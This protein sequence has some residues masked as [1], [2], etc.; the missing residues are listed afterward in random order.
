MDDLKQKSD[1]ELQD[2]M[3]AS[4]DNQ[5]VPS[6]IY[7]KAKQELEFRTST[8][9]RFDNIHSSN[10]SIGSSN[11]DQITN[12]PISAGHMQKNISRITRRSIL[13][14]LYTY[15]SDGFYGRL[16]E[17]QFWERIFELDNLPS[18]DARFDTMR[19]DIHQHRINNDD[20]D[21][22]WYIEKFDL[23]DI[24]DSVFLKF[25]A[26]F[27]HPEVREPDW[28]TKRVLDKINKNLSYDGIHL[29]EKKYVSGRPILGAKKTDPKQS[30]SQFTFATATGDSITI[31]IRKEVYD[32]IS[33]YLNNED[34]FHAV[35]EAYKVVKEKLREISGKEKASDIFNMNAENNK[36][37]ENIFGETAEVGTP[38]SD[39]FRGVG[40]LNLAI[41]F[42]RNEK[43][44]SLAT[45]IDKNLAIHYISLASLSYDLISRSDKK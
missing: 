36:H 4:I 43:S 20:W 17:V 19:G 26:E 18:S 15:F 31:E 8:P 25:I 27:F 24:E 30:E 37:H 29:Y 5:Y 34:Y 3:R 12:N 7:H 2:I 38:K 1:Q 28:N 10:I 41:Q 33:N 42:L 6:S 45:Q 9:Q 40:Y 11:I 39:F 21:D 44:H 16:D 22:K 14:L 23:L 13:E 35:E 32:H